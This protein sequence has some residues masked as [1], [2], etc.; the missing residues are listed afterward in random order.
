[1]HRN[2]I[3]ALAGAS[4]VA[5][6]DTT[7]LPVSGASSVANDE[8]MTSTGESGMSQPQP[9]QVADD[10][11]LVNPYR[12]NNADPQVDPAL[13]AQL[14]S[15]AE[16]CFPNSTSGEPDFNAPCNVYAAIEA[17]CLLGSEGLELLKNP[18]MDMI[19]R[20]IQGEV[21]E[22]TLEL[23]EQR[24]CVCQSQYLDATKGCNACG[25]QTSLYSE[26]YAERYDALVS[27][28]MDNY[29]RVDNTPT[30]PLVVQ[31]AAAIA[32]NPAE[33]LDPQVSNATSTE[34]AT[35]VSNY[36]TLSVPGSSAYSIPFP[37]GSGNATSTSLRVSGGVIVPTATAAGGESTSTADGSDGGDADG[38]DDVAESEGGAMQ[39]A[40]V[41][42][43]AFGMFACAALAVWL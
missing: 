38:E 12:G 15:Y 16:V 8:Q 29:C 11:P 39:T 25:V 34:T 6:Q 20:L 22:S 36:Y 37:T 27:D 19:M 41:G 28:V 3:L 43:Y 9:S 26:D 33:W 13:L 35:A 40:V 23:D 21:P 17:Q 31:I 24:A 30:M 1:M 7:S 2:L 14:E 10:E 32:E 42:S 5:A 4:A 18:S